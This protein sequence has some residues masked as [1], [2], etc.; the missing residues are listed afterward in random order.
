[1]DANHI[2]M[3]EEGLEHELP[4]GYD[5]VLGVDR[6]Q[7]FHDFF[8]R[9]L[10]PGDKLPPVV[11]ITFPRDSA[12]NVSPGSEISVHFAPVIDVKTI[13][14]GH[15]LKIV[16]ASDNKEIKGNWK[17]TRK[18]TKFNFIPDQ[19][20]SSNERYKVI[21]TKKVKD[22]AG[23]SLSKEKVVQFKTGV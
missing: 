4:Y 17:S 11:L 8:D 20:L 6:Y 22:K 15:A 3:L 2:S 5:H 7:L 18:D 14:E 10:K 19:P 21:I 16:R 1:M 23:T 12:E 13:Y 9:Y